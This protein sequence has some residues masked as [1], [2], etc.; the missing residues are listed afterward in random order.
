MPVLNRG[1]L[2]TRGGSIKR[3]CFARSFGYMGRA[4]FLGVS[5]EKISSQV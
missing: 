1:G 4:A 5:A 3:G 2:V